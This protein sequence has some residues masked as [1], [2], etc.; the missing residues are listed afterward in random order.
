MVKAHN[1]L[2]TEGALY[3]LAICGRNTKHS[4]YGNYQRHRQKEKLVVSRQQSET[5]TRDQ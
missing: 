5:V 1:A 4:G 2:S 3:F